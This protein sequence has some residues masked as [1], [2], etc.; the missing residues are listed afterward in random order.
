MSDA[1]ARALRWGKNQFSL[2]PQPEQDLLSPETAG[3]VALGFIPGVGQA[4]ALRDMERAR[5]ADDPVAGGLAA[6]SLLPFGKLGQ[7]VKKEIIAGRAAK[8]APHAD[9][10]A[11]EAALRAGQDPNSV[12]QTHGMYAGTENHAPS[13]WEIPDQGMTINQQAPRMSVTREGVQRIPGWDV[14]ANRAKYNGKVRH[15]VNHP[16]LAANYPELMDYIVEAKVNPGL[17]SSGG[18]QKPVAH[19]SSKS[20]DTP[21]KITVTAP[22]MDELREVLLHEL[23]HGVQNIE[24]FDPGANYQFIVDALKRSG[25]TA[26]ENRGLHAYQHN[27]GEAEA[28]VVPQRSWNS[29]EFNRAVAPLEQ[30]DVPVNK[31]IEEHNL[32]GYDIFYPK[33]KP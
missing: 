4:M 12:W 6:A 32:P 25:S 7:V 17:T 18:F 5:R 1:L 23:Q 15:L 30:Y 31:L 22:N 33:K 29:K 10:D 20:L 2:D 24:G 8:T 19:W 26:A 14:Y 3:D 28:R 27:M 13:K 11:G 16:E 9:L 21:G